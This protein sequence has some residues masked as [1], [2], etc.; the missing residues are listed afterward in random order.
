MNITTLGSYEAKNKWSQVLRRVAAGE[1]FSVTHRGTEV[2][3]I[4]PS[5][6]Q[7]LAR[8]R[9][10]AERIREG[11]RNRPKNKRRMTARQIKALITEGR[12]W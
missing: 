8:M 1:T 4:V 7:R 2:A 9:A 10:A 5:E 12:E 11:Y 6:A 3:Q